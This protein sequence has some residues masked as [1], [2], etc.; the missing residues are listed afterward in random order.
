MELLQ[1]YIFDHLKVNAREMQI[2]LA[3]VLPG[4]WKFRAEI[5]KF[6]AMKG[7]RRDAA[8]ERY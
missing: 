1:P 3:A 8:R 5:A 6:Q 4:E 7:V 2:Q